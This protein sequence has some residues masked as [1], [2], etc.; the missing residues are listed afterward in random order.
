LLWYVLKVRVVTDVGSVV[1]TSGSSFVAA[2]TL[3]S[4]ERVQG[5]GG[6]RE[7]VQEGKH[8]GG[9]TWDRRQ[10]MGKSKES[11]QGS[12]QNGRQESRQR[13]QESRQERRQEG[14]HERRQAGRE[15]G[16]QAGGKQGAAGCC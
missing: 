2:A 13:R 16:V 8:A 9:G 6:R 7:R 1:D 12:R 10:G 5:A 11:K 4:Q 3:G 15:A 14:K